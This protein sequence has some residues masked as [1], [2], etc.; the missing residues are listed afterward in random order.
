MDP[1]KRIS[2]VFE[3]LNFSTCDFLNSANSPNLLNCWS[4]T[5]LLKGFGYLM[6]FMKLNL[7]ACSRL[8]ILPDGF[9]KL[10]PLTTLDL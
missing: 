1:F 5:I 10:T 2:N 8:T 3:D 6:S 7:L 4:L 9:G